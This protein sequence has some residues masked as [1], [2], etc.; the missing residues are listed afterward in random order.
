MMNKSVPL[1]LKTFKFLN[2][3]KS[4][5]I[6]TVTVMSCGVLSTQVYAEGSAISA[7]FGTLGAGLEYERS[8]T[9]SFNGRLGFNTFNFDKDFD[10]S[11]IDYEGELDFSNVTALIDYHPGGVKFRITSGIA[12]NGNSINAIGSP[13]NGN[14]NLNGVT[15]TAAEVGTLSGD[16]E[17]DS[18]APYLGIGYGNAAKVSGS[19]GFNIDLG[20]LFSGAPK[21]NLQVDCGTAVP[22][23]ICNQIQSDANQEAVA[24]EED[25][26]DFEV[27]PVITLGISYKL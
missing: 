14:F 7:R 24:F 3:K 9:D 11:G 8:F 1:P 16:I 13:A 10:A 22:T 18:I 17:F 5:F 26:D 21:A 4:L 2:L 20:V 12:Y 19:W 15:Y 27:Y 25:L 23:M 6:L